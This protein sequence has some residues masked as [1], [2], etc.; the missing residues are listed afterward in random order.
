[1]GFLNFSTS[2]NCVIGVI[3]HLPVVP[4]G[5]PGL[6]EPGFSRVHKVGSCFSSI[7]S[8]GVTLEFY[9]FPG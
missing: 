8:F 5:V 9:G 6:L 4:E 7:Q 3:K 1:M 2:P